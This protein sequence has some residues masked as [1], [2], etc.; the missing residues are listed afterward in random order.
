MLQY[1]YLPLQQDHA[2][3]ARYSTVSVP[4][5]SA[6]PCHEGQVATVSLY[7]PLQQDH[8]M[9]SDMLH[10]LYHPSTAGQMLQYLNLPV[11]LQKDMPG[12]T[13]T[14]IGTYFYSWTMPGGTGTSIGT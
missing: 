9:R 14:S 6:G 4:T 10:Y 8:D 2:I 13:G 5:S 3:R 1:L 7:L 11:P 12:R